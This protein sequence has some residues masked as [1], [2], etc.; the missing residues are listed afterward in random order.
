MLERTLYGNTI[1]DWLI[2]AGVTLVAALVLLAIRARAVRILQRRADRHGHRV[3][4]ALA[5]LEATQPWF[6]VVVAL[7]AGA[8]FVAL[9]PKADRLVD[10]VA[11]IATIVQA[12]LWASKAIRAWLAHQVAEKRHTDAGAATTVSVLG[13]FAQLALWSLVFLLALE[14]LG[15]NITALLAGLG[16]GGIA[17]ALA[18]QSILGDVFASITIVLD[19]PFSIG[20]FIVLDDIMG[21]V[22]YIGLKTTRLR[23]LSGEQIV[24]SNSDLLKAKLR[25]FERL[26]E[27]RVQFTVAVALDTPADKLGKVP[28]MMQTSIEAQPEARFE[29]AHFKEIGDAHLTFEAAYYVSDRDYRRYMDT[30]Q[31]INLALYA[32]LQKEGIAPVRK[33]SP[34]SRQGDPRTGTNPPEDSAEKAGAPTARETVRQPEDGRRAPET[35]NAR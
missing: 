33:P 1:L 8:Q 22:E 7:F 14:N 20:D 25:N 29:R 12:A 6:L 17:V 18:A 28:A 30:Q 35:E 3:R 32:R 11:L 31:A 16:V 15:F 19:R 13:F 2:A 10:H 26:Q 21:T 5:A 34:E 23:S 9:A 4:M 27:R 24:I